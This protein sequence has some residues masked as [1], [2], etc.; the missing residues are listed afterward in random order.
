MLRSPGGALAVAVVVLALGCAANTASNTVDTASATVCDNGANGG[1]GPIAAHV[2]ADVTVP[3]GRQC[4]IVAGGV[5]NGDIEVQGILSGNI[6]VHGGEVNVHGRV[7]GNIDAATEGTI[8]AL[9]TVHG[10]IENEG[11]GDVILEP[12][13]TVAGN[14][15]LQGNGDVILRSGATVRGNIEI[16][17]GGH[18]IVEPNS[19]VRGNVKCGSGGGRIDGTV[20]GD[21]EDCQED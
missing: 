3:S 20:E 7:D 19:S 14:V 16:E 5:V 2:N 17:G 6:K 4:K 1:I 9:G 13:G 18:V 12:G 11:G 8:T 21:I 10:N 15:K